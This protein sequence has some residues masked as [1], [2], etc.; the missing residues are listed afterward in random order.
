MASRRFDCCHPAY[1]VF[2]GGDGRISVAVGG[3]RPLPPPV[4]G[5]LV[6]GV[7]SCTVGVGVGVDC[8]LR[9]YTQV[10]AEDDVL[11]RFSVRRRDVITYQDKQPAG[12]SRKIL[13]F[14]DFPGALSSFP[15]D[16]C[17]FGAFKD[18]IGVGNAG[19]IGSDSY[20][21]AGLIHN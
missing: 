6:L 9:G 2:S 11:R 10:P 3:S 21:Y 4:V 1:L 14:A 5:G 13:D 8:N 12:M 16:H 17:D 20:V 18:H 19:K 7:R 15:V